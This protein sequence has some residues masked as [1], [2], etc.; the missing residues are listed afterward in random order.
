MPIIDTT[1]S[2]IANATSASS[3]E[4]A[5]EERGRPAKK[6]NK[7]SKRR[8]CLLEKRL[9]LATNTFLQSVA[10]LAIFDGTRT[11]HLHGNF[12]FHDGA[13]SKYLF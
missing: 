13:G 1:S 9:K 7:A 2:P 3:G 11:N 5:T 10:I 8:A 12:K 4:T 6:E